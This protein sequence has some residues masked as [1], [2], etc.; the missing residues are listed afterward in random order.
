MRIL[1]P[2][3][4]FTTTHLRG[5]NS[6][7]TGVLVALEPGTGEVLDVFDAADL[8]S[9]G[10][11]G[12][13]APTIGGDDTIY[14]G[15]RGRGS[16][17]LGGTDVVNGTMYA[18]RFSRTVGF[19][20]IWEFEVDG[21]LDWVPPAIGDNG[22]LYFGSSDTFSGIEQAIFY[23]LD[24]IPENTSAKFYAIFE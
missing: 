24:E 3:A 13:T 1:T 20:L 6:D 15:V 22:G 12:M 2:T 19:E 18:I 23:D 8:D 11:G 10:V 16:G 9:P 17:I 14:V 21:L 5:L 4:F 7:G